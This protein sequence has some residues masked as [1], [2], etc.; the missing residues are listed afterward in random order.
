MKTTSKFI[1]T[2]LI[3]LQLV[4]CS[5]VQRSAQNEPA[6]ATRPPLAV[7]SKNITDFSDALRCM[8]ESFVRY[9]TRDV[10]IIAEDFADTTK[11]VSAC[12]LYTS[13]SPRD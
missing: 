10:S 2:T 11:K 7:P 13:P 12:L 6:T 8:D 9:G 4:A 5:S 1:L 3:G